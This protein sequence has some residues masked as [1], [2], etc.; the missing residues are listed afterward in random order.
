MCG[1]SPDNGERV[2]TFA[3]TVC[4]YRRL[5]RVE[6]LV[7]GAG[8]A[9]DLQLGVLPVVEHTGVVSR[10]Y[11]II[12]LFGSH[13]DIDMNSERSVQRVPAAVARSS[14]TILPR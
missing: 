8:E 3:A 13:Q 10:P 12:F 11:Y 4:L 5:A 7:S 14:L 2:G 6:T 1:Y 9:F